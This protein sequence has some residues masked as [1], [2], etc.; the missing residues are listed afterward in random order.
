MLENVDKVRWDELRD[1]KGPAAEVPRLLRA[2]AGSD[3]QAA[4]KAGMELSAR[5]GPAGHTSEAAP[6][7]I[8]FLIEI[9][10]AEGGLF[11]D[12]ILDTITGLSVGHP[13]DLLTT[14]LDPAAPQ[15]EERYRG[16]EGQLRKAAHD[17]ARA[18][19]PV[20]TALLSDPDPHVR[21]FAA[22]TL[23]WFPG[24]AAAILPVIEQRLSAE[25]EEA[26]LGSLLLARA[27]LA[28]ASGAAAG[29][30][31]SFAEHPSLLVRVAWAFGQFLIERAA[32]SEQAFSV[33]ASVPRQTQVKPAVFPWDDGILDRLADRALRDL[34]A[35]RPAEVMGAYRALLDRDPRTIQRL[36]ARHFSPSKDPLPASA[37]SPMQREILEAIDDRTGLWLAVGELRNDLGRAGLPK[38]PT[39]L[40]AY[41]GRPPRPT[42][43]DVQ[44]AA[45]GEPARPLSAWLPEIAAGL[46]DDRRAQLLDAI[47]RA[48]PPEGRLDLVLSAMVS[49]D[50]MTPALRS[51]AVDVLDRLRSEAPDVFDPALKKVLAEGVPMLVAKDWFASYPHV[52]AFFAAAIARAA[53]REGKDIPEVVDELLA[54][55]LKDGA[56]PAAVEVLPLVPEARREPLVL[57]PGPNPT[58]PGDWPI[59]DLARSPK[60]REK[61]LGT[62]RKWTA[63]T[64]HYNKGALAKALAGYGDDIV[65]DLVALANDK[66]VVHRDIPLLALGKIGSVPSLTALLPFASDRTKALKEGAQKALT[67]A[68]LDKAAPALRAALADPDK[69]ARK[70]AATALGLLPN[71]PEKSAL[72]SEAL[73]SEKAKDVKDLLAAIA[74]APGKS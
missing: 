72:A 11:R 27:L 53:Q 48:V 5:L 23:A 22:H 39:S 63:D 41:L 43:L 4:A 64:P 10:G 25:K 42:P 57:L 26:P 73:A 3:P 52:V 55:V 70:N 49:A 30:A 74:A 33:L 29:P 13:H 34:H 47:S 16:P 9:L 50:S 7:A 54:R 35:S 68:G 59:Y 20:Y 18:G 58:A 65:A 24:D 36:V 32:L 8:P 31:P 14:G 28:R 56:A 61:L 62:V 17:A 51:W 45:A 66:T 2:L 12:N 19:V 44:V 15:V 6:A 37:L 60:I 21:T 1:S 38:G 71:S 46:P 69:A 67:E 40:R